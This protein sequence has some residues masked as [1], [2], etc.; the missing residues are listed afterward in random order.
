MNIFDYAMELEKEGEKHY[1]DLARKVNNEGLEKIFNWLA[2]EEV[3]HYNVFK[4]MKTDQLPQMAQTTVLGSAKK[5]FENMKKSKQDLEFH[6]GSHEVKLY[7]KAKEIE[8]KSQNFYTQKSKE[9]KDQAQKD[10]F[11]KIAEEER[12]HYFLLENISQFVSRPE[13]WLENAEWYHLDE[14]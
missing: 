10:M 13:K 3:K 14:Y 6:F 8:K 4:E 5:V 12:K 1:R 7:D 11:L 2:N 9:V